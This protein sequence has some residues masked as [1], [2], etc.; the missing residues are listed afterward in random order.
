MELAKELIWQTVTVSVI[1]Q[2]MFTPL[3][4]L[5]ETE[6]IFQLYGYMLSLAMGLALTNGMLA[7]EKGAKV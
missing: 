2:Q 1:I 4:L 6:Y 7:D 3:P 5:L